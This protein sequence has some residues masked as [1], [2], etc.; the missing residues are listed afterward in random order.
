MGEKAGIRAAGVDGP[1]EGYAMSNTRHEPLPPPSGSA[2]ISA[3]L[4]WLAEHM[5]DV[6]TS[7]DYYGGM[8]YR[9]AERGSELVS[10]GII[11]RS[12][13]DEIDKIGGAD[14]G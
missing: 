2:E 10:A 13:A 12:W 4:R 6:G 8:N 9:I 11:A 1:A 14:R 3:Q 5:I 7:M